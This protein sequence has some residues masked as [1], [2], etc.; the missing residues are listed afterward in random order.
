VASTVFAEPGLNVVGEDST[1]LARFPTAKVCFLQV[2]QSTDQSQMWATA[3]FVET[4]V[5]F[6]LRV[7]THG[8]TGQPGQ[9]STLPT[10]Y[11]F[12]FPRV[13]TNNGLSVGL[14]K[15]FLS[16]WFGMVESFFAELLPSI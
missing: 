5:P 14:K 12:C 8:Q 16:W 9:P 7:L 10:F 15:K 13:Q 2:V 1:E 4:R 3:P 11:V 6:F